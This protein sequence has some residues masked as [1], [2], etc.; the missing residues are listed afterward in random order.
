MKINIDRLCTLAGLNSGSKRRPLR[1]ASNRSLHDD[2]SVSA[3]A[4]HRFGKNQLNEEMYMDE[5]MEEGHFMEEDH[6]MEE[7]MEEEM[8]EVDEAMLVQELRRAKK[9][10][11][12]SRRRRQRRSSK[13]LNEEAKLKRIIEE[14]VANVM[15][16]F[17]LNSSWVY[18]KRTPTRSRK[19]H[20]HQG[21][22]LKG[23]GF[24]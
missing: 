18:G 17:N 11:A 7:G 12:E 20:V 2:P 9:I 14:E 3:E 21:S 10:M 24:K 6:C 1:E 4:E 15:E 16:E 23:I 13:S 5:D 22:F 19:G 8:V